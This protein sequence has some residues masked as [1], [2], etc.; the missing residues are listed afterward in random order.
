LNVVCKQQPEH[1]H[2]KKFYEEEE[3]LQARHAH[4]QEVA[5]DLFVPRQPPPP[6]SPTF[7]PC[8]VLVPRGAK[9]GDNAIFTAIQHGV[10]KR[11][12]IVVRVRR[13]EYAFPVA[14]TIVVAIFGP[15]GGGGGGG[16]ITA[17]ASAV[18]YVM[19]L[20]EICRVV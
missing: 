11:R 7:S 10:V 5:S 6:Y 12:T 19:V 14:A 20:V 15:R 2:E 18:V 8:D 17:V 3:D 16:G 4:G 13:A 9:N 1:R